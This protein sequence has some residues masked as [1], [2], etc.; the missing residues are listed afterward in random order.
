MLFRSADDE[1]LLRIINFPRRGIGEASIEKLRG[2]AASKQT[3]LYGVITTCGDEVGG[4][5]KPK[6]VELAATLSK[7][8][9]TAAQGS[10]VQYF[11]YLLFCVLNVN[12]LF[13]KNDEDRTR[14]ENLN[15]LLNSVAEFATNNGDGTLSDYLQTVSLYS[16]GDELTG[17]NAVTVATVHSAKGLEFPVVFVVGLE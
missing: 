3:S 1:A 17:D 4:A 14:L 7:L 8:V 13:S 12:D 10:V 9:E 6:L 2:I 15:E 5:L 16:D 11:K